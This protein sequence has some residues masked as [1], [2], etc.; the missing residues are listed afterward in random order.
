MGSEFTDILIIRADADL[1]IGA[2]HVMRSLALAEAW[3]KKRGLVCFVTRCEQEQLRARI[4]RSVDSMRLL[5]SKST[6]SGAIET[7]SAVAREFAQEVTLDSL[8]VVLDGYHLGANYQQALTQLGLKVLIIDDYAH[9]AQYECHLLLNYNLD[10]ETRTYCSTP[11]TRILAGP[12]YFPLRSDLL[13]NPRREKTAPPLA[14]RIVVTFGASDPQ[15]IST[16][17]IQALSTLDIHDLEV[18]VV[19]GALNKNAPALA[20]EVGKL[21]STIRARLIENPENLN[22][23]LATSDLAISAGGVTSLELAHL[24]V[25]T[26]VICVAGNQLAASKALAAHGVTLNLGWHEE[27]STSTLARTLHQLI[28][29][30]TQ[31]TRMAELGQ[32]LIDGRGATRIVEEM[33]CFSLRLRLIQSADAEMIWQWANDP[34]TRAMSFSSAPIPWEDHL[35]W[36]NE[37]LRDSNHLFFVAENAAGVPIGQV[38]FQVNGTQAIISVS[39]A[40]SKRGCGYGRSLID[41]GVDELFSRTMVQEVHAAIKSSNHSSI[42]VFREAGFFPAQEKSMPKEKHLD[43][44]NYVLIR[45]DAAQRRVS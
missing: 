2:G 41:Q 45:D 9:L 31:R 8:W 33:K 13:R 27:V 25:P 24:G 22:E 16:R 5:S 20:V 42:S 15:N 37:K 17:V 44:L 34:E 26:I 38:R 36:F 40:P 4:E 7:L 23:V 6:E 12:R 14:K 11:Q 29:D 30:A 10:A 28:H 21:P 39:V 18:T 3:R 19:V 35:A 32:K 1:E 43:A